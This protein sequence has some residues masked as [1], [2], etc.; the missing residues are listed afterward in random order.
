MKGSTNQHDQYCASLEVKPD[1][2]LTAEELV[3]AKKWLAEY[4]FGPKQ[5]RKKGEGAFFRKKLRQRWVVVLC[6]CSLPAQHL[7]MCQSSE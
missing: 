7:G 5:R 1:Y 4:D 2:G 3:E 6:Q